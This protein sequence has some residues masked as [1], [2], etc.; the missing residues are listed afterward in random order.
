M[1]RI[2]LGACLCAVVFMLLGPAVVSGAETSPTVA[3]AGKYVISGPFVHK[4]LAVFLVLGEDRIKGKTFI[5]L[6][7]ALKRKLVVVHE[8]GNVQQLSVENKS[9]NVHIYIQSGVI[10]KGGKQDRTIRYDMVL[11]PKSGKMP[12]ASFCV[13]SGRWS[14]RGGESSKAFSSAKS[15]LA[16]KEL[17][18]ASK[19]KGSQQAVWASVAKA[20]GDLSANLK[21]SVQSGKSATSLQLTLENKK[22]GSMAKEYTTSLAKAFA[23]RKK[24]I[25]YA[26]AINGKIN[27]VDVYGS[28]KLFAMLRPD[29]LKAAAVEAIASLD[30]DKKKPAPSAGDVKNAFLEAAKGKKTEKNLAGKAKLIIKETKKSVIFS[31]SDDGGSYRDEML[32][33]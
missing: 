13:E 14:K 3:R 19:L 25:G 5:T 17:K 6:D 21:Q 33:K 24:V 9:P 31:A 10:V 22:L 12:I 27:G 30:K 8:T 20:Q 26:F 1:R 7:D 2:W 15:N 18:I 4:N 32:L 23:G 29:L 28:Q 16:T 11:P